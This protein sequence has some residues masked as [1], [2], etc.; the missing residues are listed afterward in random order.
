MSIT[1]WDPFRELEDMNQRSKLPELRSGAVGLLDEDAVQGE[2]VEVWIE[3]K[4]I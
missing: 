2:D 1:R 3:S 4:V